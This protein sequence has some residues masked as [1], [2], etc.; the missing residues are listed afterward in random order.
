MP[1]SRQVSMRIVRQ[2]RADADQD[3][4]A[5]RAQQMH[6]RLRGL[7]RDRDRLAA[8]GADLVVGARPRA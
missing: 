3:G 5:L 2:H 4:V 8:G 1:G 6:P 7:A